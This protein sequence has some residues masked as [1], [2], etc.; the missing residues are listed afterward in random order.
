MEIINN[1]SIENILHENKKYTEIKIDKRDVNDE[2]SEKKEELKKIITK[3]IVEDK[4]FKEQEKKIDYLQS[5]FKEIS[6]DF[7]KEKN[8]INSNFITCINDKFEEIKKNLIQEINIHFNKQF[9]EIL[10]LI[11]NNH[12]EIINKC[13]QNQNIIKTD[14]TRI[15]KDIRKIQ[16]KLNIEKVQNNN[17]INIDNSNNNNNFNYKKINTI[18]I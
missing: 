17:N 16:N 2:F 9:E 11:K 4:K 12:S 6:D 1:N 15:I 7:Q 13:I 10:N 14:M 18:K 3:E 5:Q 8:K